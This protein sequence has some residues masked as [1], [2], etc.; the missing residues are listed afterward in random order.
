MTILASTIARFLDREMSGPDLELTHPV[1]AHSPASGALVFVKAFSEAW[2]DSLGPRQDICVLGPPEFASRL[3]G[4]LIISDSPR[5]DF[6]R[7]VEKFFVPAEPRVI[8]DT[9]RIHPSAHIGQNVGIGHYSVIGEG[10]VI[11]DGTVIR[12]HVVIHRNCRIG[13]N[14]LIKSSTVIGEEG[15]G[16]EFDA[17]GVP[18]RIPHL[19]AVVLGD[20]VE[21]GAMNVIARGTLGDTVLSDHVKTDDHVFIAH[22]VSVGE[23]TVIIACAEVSGSV[24]LGRDV[25]IAPSACIINQATVGDRGMVGLGAVVTKSV[26]AGMIVAGNPAKVIRPRA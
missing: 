20:E 11:G 4:A 10:A 7:A 14:C 15:F 25:W 9:A 5:L 19:G 8:S 2:V 21:I 26:E 22:N 13:R 18:M 12:S 3:Q 24:K 17:E 6:A 1:P 23:N 16:F